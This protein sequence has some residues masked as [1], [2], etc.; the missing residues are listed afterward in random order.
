MKNVTSCIFGASLILFGQQGLAQTNFEKGLE[1]ATKAEQ[2]DDGFKD[3]K[4]KVEMI[5][6]N[7]SGVSSTRQIS[8]KTME[9]SGQ[10]GDKS[11]LVFNSPADQR[12]TALL[13]HNK[14]GED[15]EQWLY[16]PAL[17][18]VK[19]IASSNKSGPFVGSEF[20]FEDIGGR[21][22]EDYSY[23]YIKDDTLNEQECHVVE[24]YPKSKYSGYKRLLTWFDKQHFRVLKVEFYDKKDSHLKTLLAK[25]YHLYEDSYWRAHILEMT[26]HQT[27]S[28]TVLKSSDYQFGLGARDKEFSKAA[29]KRIR[30]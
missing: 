14:F 11:V 25:D 21:E 24:S 19:R 15:N 9:G 17:K 3:V 12:G 29:L 8:F 7:K 13:T 23:L 10:A 5:L 1:I 2:K 22:L 18:R 28:V 30:L 16:L 27:K 4:S 26:N 20:A 6:T